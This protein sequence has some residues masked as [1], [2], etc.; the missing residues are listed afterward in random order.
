MYICRGPI[1]ENSA[2]GGQKK[3]YTDMV[4]NQL[5]ATLMLKSIKRHLSFSGEPDKIELEL[6]ENPSKLLISCSVSG[7]LPPPVITLSTSGYV[8]PQTSVFTSTN[9]TTVTG[10]VYTVRQ[11]CHTVHGGRSRY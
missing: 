3:F 10:S 4:Y 2:S 7:S 8:I 5:C 9:T 11:C 6:V 1:L